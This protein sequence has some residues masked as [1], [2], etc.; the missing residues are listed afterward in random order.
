MSKDSN[1][2]NNS[3]Y[4]FGNYPLLE[5]LVSQ[6]S[7]SKK[8]D[9]MLVLGKIS[10]NQKNLIK[11][12]E[13]E[14]TV[15]SSSISLSKFINKKI[16]NTY[17]A[18]LCNNIIQYQ[19]NTGFFLD[20]IFDS[21]KN[22]GQ[23]IITGPKNK[24]DVLEEANLFIP[25]LTLLIQNLIYSG[26]DAKDCKIISFV[27]ENSIIIKK[28]KDFKFLERNETGYKWKEIHHK[29][30]PFAK[31]ISGMSIHEEKIFFVNCN[32]WKIGPSFGESRLAIKP[33]F[34]ENYLPKNFKLSFQVPQK[35]DFYEKQF[36]SSEKISE[37]VL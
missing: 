31:L 33:E 1:N 2:K 4:I 17:D 7:N 5:F 20:K 23:L 9:K 32:F 6:K 15:I 35:V 12:F 13:Y 30:S 11:K 18:I 29:R 37:I 24:A 8:K 16:S 19:K 26:F 10:N 22:E 36:L 3:F 27:E 34:P 28:A 21:L 14:P 25:T